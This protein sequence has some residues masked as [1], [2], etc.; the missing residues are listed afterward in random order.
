MSFLHS[1]L[2]RAGQAAKSAAL[3]F[4]GVAGL[5]RC[6]LAGEGAVLAFHG[7]RADGVA[8]GVSDEGLHLRL[9]TFRAVCERLA[10]GYEVMRLAEMA[11]ILERGE[12][13]PERAVALTFDDG[14]ASNYELGYPVLRDLGLPTTIFLATGFLDGDAPL[15]FQQVDVAMRQGGRVGNTRTLGEALAHLKRLPDEVMREEVRRL[16]E[17]VTMPLDEPEVMRPMTWAQAREMQEG[18][19]VDFGGHTHTH[20]I[21]SRCGVEKQRW[22]IRMCADRIRAELGAEPSAF[23][24]PNGG[25]D[26]YTPETLGVLK[27]VGYQSAWTTVCG[28]VNTAR[29]RMMMPRYGAPESVWEA[30]ATVSGAFDLVRRWKG[31]VA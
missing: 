26:D 13:L 8:T 28:R 16:V 15:W 19:L 6:Q 25:V 10:K 30:E 21:L 18:G 17:S 11:E 9:S 23:A 22:E 5:A 29:N 24:F 7:L 14:Y 20:P 3:V 31:G 27:E 12:R 2:S 4:C 1:S